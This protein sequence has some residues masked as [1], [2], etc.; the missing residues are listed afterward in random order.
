MYVFFY[1]FIILGVGWCAGIFFI[2]MSERAAPP[3]KNKQTNKQTF[4][5]NWGRLSQF[6]ENMFALVDR[7]QE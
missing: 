1:V 3:Q 6:A 5:S 4:L 7:T 2:F